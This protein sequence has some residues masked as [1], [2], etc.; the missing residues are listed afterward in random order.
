MADRVATLALGFERQVGKYG[1]RTFLREKR[2]KEWQSHSFN[3]VSA[4]ACR[5]HGG[6]AQLGIR[7]GDRIGILS[8]NSPQWIIVDQA[9]LGLGAV[10]VPL[11]TTSGVE[12]TR[13]VIGD[14][15]A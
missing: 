5:L 8:D 6:L 4:A 10:V 13:H 12:E 9:T 1:D 15:G 2:N 11:Y 14:S 3:A 7:P